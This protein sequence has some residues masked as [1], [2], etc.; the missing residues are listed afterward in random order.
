MSS[1][2]FVASISGTNPIDA[3]PRGALLEAENAALK[4]LLA[5]RERRIRLLEEALRWLKAERYGASRER[6]DATPAQRGLFNEVEVLAELAEVTG[7]EPPLTATP[8]REAKPASKLKPGRRALAAHLPRREVRH[9]LPAVERICDCGSPLREIGAEV[10]EQL[11]YVPARVEVVRH[12]RVKYACPGCEA[13]VKTAPAV[14]QV[15]P[16]S[17]AAAGLLAQLVTAKY[18]DA[19]PLHRQEAMFARH[20]VALPRATQAAWLIGLTAP[21]TPLMNLLDERLRESGYIR[22]DETPVQVIHSDEKT[23]AAEHWMWVRVAGPPRQRIILFDYDASRAGATAER[24]LAGAR[25]FLQTDGYAAYDGV[26]ARLA[27]IHVGCFAHARRKGFEA[28]KA[29]PAG[30]AANTPAHE[31]VRRIDALY[32]IEREVKS[33]A[34]EER[35]RVRAERAQPLLEH[36]HSWA[37]E[38][39]GQTLPSGKLGVAFGYL[40]GQWPKLVRYLDDPRLAID[41]N[42]AENA[43]RPFALGRRY[44]RVAIMQGRSSAVIARDRCRQLSTRLDGDGSRRRVEV[45]TV[46]NYRPCRNWSTRSD[47]R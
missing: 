17:N 47:G 16:K 32:A 15:L 7:L 35:T 10:S 4:D 9:E 30:T 38:Q 36:L 20:G 13:C 5:A 3:P 6:L 27:L 45:G 29:L 43:I 26:A 1:A 23:R 8:L 31:L 46:H 19:L 2:P 28:I 24:L 18:V 22:M 11:D 39:A 12:V 21:L 40:L 42:L 44:A 41:T 34:P 33:L 14:V 25:G 37:L